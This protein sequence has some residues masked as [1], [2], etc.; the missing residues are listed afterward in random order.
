MTAQA[1]KGAVDFVLGVLA[2]AASV[3]QDDVGGG[4]LVGQFIA[5]SAQTADHQLAVEYV[6][7]AANGFDVEFFGHFILVL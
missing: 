5:L 2:D 6:H 3:E 1:A 7:L 4:G